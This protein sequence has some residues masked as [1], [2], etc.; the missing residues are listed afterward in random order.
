MP[1]SHPNQ[2]NQILEVFLKIRPNSVLDV[3]VGFGKIGVLAREYL[4]FW[5]GTQDYKN[6]RHK[7]DGVEVF[8]H[9]LTPL[10]EF[11]YNNIYIGEASKVLPK[12]TEK[13]DLLL[14]IDVI[15]H[16]TE[17]DG[18]AFLDLCFKRARNVLISTPR[19]MNAQGDTFDNSY[20]THLFQWTQE[21]FN[22][23]PNSVRLHTNNDS[24]IFLI[25]ED[26]KK[27]RLNA[28]DR[29]QRQW[30]FLHQFLRRIKRMLID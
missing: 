2:L 28:R 30:P 5:D 12:L 29:F 11:I 8:E 19:E 26:S 4:E 25:G 24:L 1:T 20:E 13:Y 16:F 3:G 14:I 23:Y 22:T 9:Y 6:W 18:L 10:H 27:V 7:I 15:E 21:H 17:A